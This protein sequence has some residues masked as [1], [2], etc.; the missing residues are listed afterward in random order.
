MIIGSEVIRLFCNGFVPSNATH[1]VCNTQI[2]LFIY[3]FIITTCFDHYFGHH[4]VNN[5]IYQMIK[6]HLINNVIHPM[7]TEIMVETC[8]DNK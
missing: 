6:A 8:S 4:Q 5:I 1:G 7:M 2:D 3:L